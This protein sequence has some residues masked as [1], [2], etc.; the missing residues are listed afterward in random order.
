MAQSPNTDPFNGYTTS[1]TQPYASFDEFFR[2]KTCEE[3][4]NDQS[5]ERELDRLEAVDKLV[6]SQLTYDLAD[7]IINKV[8]QTRGLEND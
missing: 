5:V 6:E 7:A 4:Y 8:K 1:W 3:I 2:G